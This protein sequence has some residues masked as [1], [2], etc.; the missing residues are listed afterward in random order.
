MASDFSLTTPAIWQRVRLLS[1]SLLSIIWIKQL[2][3]LDLEFG[4]ASIA[5]LYRCRVGSNGR[6]LDD[7]TWSDLDLDTYC[8]QLSRG[9]SIFGLQQLYSA[10]RLGRDRIGIGAQRTR[11]LAICEQHTSL[12]ALRMEMIPLRNV[13]QELCGLLFEGA[14]PRRPWWSPYAF[15]LPITMTVSL[16]ACFFMPMFLIVAV[17]LLVSFIAIQSRYYAEVEDWEATWDAVRK[18]LAVTIGI[19]K[20]GAD[21]LRVLSPSYPFGALQ[22]HASAALH[23]LS[24]S[25]FIDFIPGLRAYADWYFLRNITGH[26]KSYSIFKANSAL[27]IEC[28][29]CVSSFE[30]DLMLAQ[31]LSNNSGRCWAQWSSALQ[32]DLVGLVHP[33]LAQAQPID[34]NVTDQSI[35]ITGK[36]GS[37]KSTLIRT[38]GINVAIARAFGFCYATSAIIPYRKVYSSIQIQDSMGTGNSFYMAEVLRARDMI[39]SSYLEDGGIYLFDE[40]FRGT[41]HLESVS[42]AAAVLQVLVRRSV[43]IATTHSLELVPILAGTFAALKLE[44]TGDS[45][46]LSLV[47]GVLEDTNGL[48][49]LGKLGIH[50][51]IEQNARDIAA[52]LTK[53]LTRSM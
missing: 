23:G 26:L 14:A 18:L 28:Y 25:P 47:P 50:T 21:K 11:I 45:Q 8:G 2:E 43:V 36:N 35:I 42:A 5:A 31:H 16:G 44:R 7:Q 27:I 32:F 52:R 46:E 34:F 15:L 19:S 53:Y 24:P 37:G 12:A 13:S 40:I 9:F 4:R 29:D 41:N 22:K 51:N 6:G 30:L 33:M 1:R 10:L 20:A 17:P 48:S 38:I 39:E 3:P 49:M